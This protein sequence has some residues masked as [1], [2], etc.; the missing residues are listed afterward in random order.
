LAGQNPEGFFPLFRDWQFPSDSSQKTERLFT[1]STTCC[2]GMRTARPITQNGVQSEWTMSSDHNTDPG[3]T[4]ECRRSFSM[5][6]AWKAL[7]NSIAPVGYEDETDF[8]YDNG[9]EANG[10]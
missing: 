5:S 7:K 9:P 6:G 4:A 1:L 8:H 3:S 10:I 2:G